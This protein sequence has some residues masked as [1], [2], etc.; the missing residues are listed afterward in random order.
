[1]DEGSDR[2]P[3]GTL[4]R[5]KSYTH[6]NRRIYEVYSPCK[7]FIQVADP[8]KREI[9]KVKSLSFKK[10]RSQYVEASEDVDDRNAQG[11]SQD[12]PIIRISRSQPNLCTGCQLSI[13]HND[14]LVVQLHEQLYHVY[15]FQCIQCDNKIDPKVDYILIEGGN[16]L[17]GTCIP[18]CRACGETIVSN[19]VNVINKDFHEQCLLCTICRKVK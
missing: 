1:M 14:D 18:E 17:C 16:P 4:K 6:V 5:K 10:R 3:V 19:H 13:T 8:T 2:Q 7:E 12:R 11:S 15:C 9:G